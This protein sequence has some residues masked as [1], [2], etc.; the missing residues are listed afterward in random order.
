MHI[1]LDPDGAADR[2][3]NAVEGYEQR[4]ASSLHDLA[5]VL[6]D[7]RI[8]HGAADRSQSDNR[9]QI[10]NADEA[11]IADHV[12]IDDRDQLAALAARSGKVR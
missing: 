3:G 4:V 2:S 11:A 8:D 7:C 10:I 1:R 6:V 12:G 5:T 9:A